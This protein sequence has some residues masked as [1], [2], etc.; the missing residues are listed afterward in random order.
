MAAFQT[1]DLDAALDRL[2]GD[3]DVLREV[4]DLFLKE[5][6]KMMAAVEHALETGDAPALALAAHS[7]KG[8]VSTFGARQAFEAARALEMAGRTANL[9]QAG[10]D[11]IRLCSAIEALTP[12]LSALAGSATID[13]A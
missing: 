1:L 8:C 2:G 12:E 4:A 5:T 6:P 7:L 13:L 9:G 3:L 10:R 11:L